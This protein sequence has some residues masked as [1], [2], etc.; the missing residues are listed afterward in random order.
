[1]LSGHQGYTESITNDVY[2]KMLAHIG[3]LITTLHMQVTIEW[4]RQTGQSKKYRQVSICL[5]HALC[6]STCTAQR[7]LPQLLLCQVWVHQ[8]ARNTMADR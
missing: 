4:M 8:V 7:L 6:N 1:M 5:C 3:H 2:N